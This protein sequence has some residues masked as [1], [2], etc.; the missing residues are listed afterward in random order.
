MANVGSPARGYYPDRTSNIGAVKDLFIK[1][2][3]G[4][5]AATI[6]Q[7]TLGEIA[8]IANTG[9]GAYTIQLT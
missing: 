6:T 9:T 5:S 3:I 8:S 2:T 4:A 7:Q 1:F